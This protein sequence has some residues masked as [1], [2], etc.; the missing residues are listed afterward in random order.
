MRMKKETGEFTPILH[1][2]LFIKQKN[3]MLALVAYLSFMIALGITSMNAVFFVHDV[4]QEK[5]YIR[6][7][8]SI[9]MLFSSFLTMPLW[10]RVAKKIGHSLTFTI[11]LIFMGIS[12]LLYL[13][14][15][16]FAIYYF[17]IICLKFFILTILYSY[18]L[19]F[20]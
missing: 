5:Q 9:F 6:T 4:L 18:S 3:F 13:F 16:I 14:M 7:I 19:L 8:G 17:M 2:Y 15:K 11:G 1:K 10:I 12:Y 20:Y